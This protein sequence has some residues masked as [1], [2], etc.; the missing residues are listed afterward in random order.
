MNI[1][2]IVT[3][4]E[5]LSPRNAVKIMHQRRL[6]EKK[7]CLYPDPSRSPFSIR[8]RSSR[9]RRSH[10][11]KSSLRHYHVHPKGYS[12]DIQLILFLT[13]PELQDM[14]H[15]FY[16]VVWSNGKK[17]GYGHITFSPPFEDFVYATSWND[18]I[19]SGT[20]YL[21][22]QRTNEVIAHIVNQNVVELLSPEALDTPLQSV[23][24]EIVDITDSAST[25]TE[26]ETDMV[27]E[28]FAEHTF[29]TKTIRE[30]SV[31]ITL[32]NDLPLNTVLDNFSGSRWEGMVWRGRS[33]GYGEYYDDR[34]ELV[35]SGMSIDNVW[36]GRGTLYYD[37]YTEAGLMV[38]SQGMWSHGNLLGWSTVY[39]R[40]GEVDG[41][42]LWLDSHL[43]QTHT[44]SIQCDSDFHQAHCF[45]REL[46]IANNMLNSL[47]VL[48]LESFRY[49]EQLEIGRHSLRHCTSFVITK[50]SRLQSIQIGEYSFTS[51][52]TALDLLLSESSR[53]LSKPKKMEIENLAVLEEIQ[54]GKG[55]FSDFS[56]C[57]FRNLPSLK[58]LT[59]GEEQEVSCNFFYTEHFSLHRKKI[60]EDY[61]L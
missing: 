41:E 19:P 56:T 20:G 42:G 58:T 10:V 11:T 26:V 22:N 34:G 30:G 36:E 31:T 61:N 17:N 44:L 15:S 35:Y 33:C 4:M 55:S 18:D 48:N 23:F 27:G 24:T 46:V 45:L 40:R 32:V 47:S 49:L 50:L 7:H 25:E 12:L 37:I 14:T 43:I 29:P 13:T 2:T 16:S 21:F 3:K 8:S 60:V 28:V 53:I 54:I 1:N 57:S 39:D 9:R 5:L 59:I 38:A 51:Y 6:K 52:D